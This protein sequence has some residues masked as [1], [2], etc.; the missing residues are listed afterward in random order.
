MTLLAQ[1]EIREVSMALI[2]PPNLAV[3]MWMD[4]DGMLEL[5]ESMNKVGLQVPIKVRPVG[6]RYEVVYGH[7][8]F[9]AAG[10][11]GWSVIRSI[12]ED[13]S[14]LETVIARYHENHGRDEVNPIEDAY[15]LAELRD[16]HGFNEAELCDAVK[17]S[18]QYVARRLN[19][20]KLDVKL[21]D[22]LAER[23]ISMAVAELLNR[24]TSDDMRN[25]YLHHAIQGEHSKNTVKRW[26]EDWMMNQTSVGAPPVSNGGP[27]EEASVA[28]VQMCCEICG[29]VIDTYNLRSIMVHSWELGL[30]RKMIEEQKKKLT[31]EVD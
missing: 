10:R 16:K 17:K 1:Q 4:E 6:E 25:M 8:R 22:S 3:R 21:V 29:P 13:L 15:Y 31:G 7:R 23:K 24:V 2:D 9:T 27:V 26:V 11:L 5:M 19:L 14:D 20:L 12:V 30:F 18:P 28:M